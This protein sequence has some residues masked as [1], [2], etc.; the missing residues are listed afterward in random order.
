[1]TEGVNVLALSLL[2]FAAIALFVSIM[3]IANTFSIL[4]TQRLRDFALL[5]CVGATRKQVLRSVRIEA[6]VIGIAASLLGLLLGTG[7]GYGLVA[8][9][10]RVIPSAAMGAVEM[11]VGWYLAA[12]VV[13]VGVTLVASWLPTRRVVRVSP[14]VALRPDDGIDARTTA[15]RLRIATGFALGLVGVPHSRSQF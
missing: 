9:T 13:G 2:L 14:L 5:R 11:S 1:M 12:F 6:L 15:G 7:V 4:F 10:E 3:V 8:L